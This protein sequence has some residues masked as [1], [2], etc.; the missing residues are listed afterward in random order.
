VSGRVFRPRRV[1]RTEERRKPF[2]SPLCRGGS[3]DIPDRAHRRSYTVVSIPSVSGRVFRLRFLLTN[4]DPCAVSI[5]SVSGRVFRRSTF[6]HVPRTRHVSI[7]S[8]SGRVFRPPTAQPIPSRGPSVSIP[9]VPG[10]VFRRAGEV[11][12]S[13]PREV[14]IPSVSGRVFRRAVQAFIN[15]PWGVFQSPLC[16]GGSSD[17][18]PGGSMQDA[19]HGFNPLCVGAGLQT[20]AY[21]RSARWTCSFQSPL[22]RGGSS[23]ANKPQRVSYM[24]DKFQ[25]P[26]C[27]GGSSDLPTGGGTILVGGVSIPSVSGR[28]FRQGSHGPRC[29]QGYRFN[30]LC[31]GAG[32]QTRT[33]P[34]RSSP[35]CWL[36]VNA[37]T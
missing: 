13:H 33:G 18:R 12:L 25:S 20:G 5:P 24:N 3:S 9:S 36:T 15:D 11:Q 32:L 37:T 6:P 19:T 7:P 35:L 21:H 22:C 26:L 10:R 23:D 14:S 28:V 16:R 8:V 34:S 31:V 29:S 2:Q 27:R 4:V 30:P 17:P 1:A